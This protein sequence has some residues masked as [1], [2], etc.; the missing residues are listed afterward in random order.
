VVV[1]DLFMFVIDE[2]D[3][4][5]STVPRLSYNKVIAVNWWEDLS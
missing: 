2:R 4:L 5:I 3:D 1:G